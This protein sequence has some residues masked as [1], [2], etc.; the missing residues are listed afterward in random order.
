MIYSDRYNFVRITEAQALYH[1]KNL[2]FCKER[3]TEKT[4]EIVQVMITI[5][6]LRYCSLFSAKKERLLK[7]QSTRK[8]ISPYG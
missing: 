3:T 8:T 4:L 7:V 6:K 1:L 5:S 2:Y